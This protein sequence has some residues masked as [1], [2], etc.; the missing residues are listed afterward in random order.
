MKIA[1]IDETEI[2]MQTDAHG[3]PIIVVGDTPVGRV[4]A[5][6]LDPAGEV[7]TLDKERGLILLHHNRQLDARLVQYIDLFAELRR[8]APRLIQL[9]MFTHKTEL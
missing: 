8:K 1:I 9:E 6:L 7:R 3:E 5:S 2:S 4:L